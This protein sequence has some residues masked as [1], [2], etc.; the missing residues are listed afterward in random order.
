MCNINKIDL[1]LNPFLSTSLVL[2]RLSHL[3]F[4]LFFFLSFL[5]IVYLSLL[6]SFSGSPLP[7]P[8]IV[9]VGVVQYDNFSEGEVFTYNLLNGLKGYRKTWRELLQ[10]KKCH[11][12]KYLLFPWTPFVCQKLGLRKSKSEGKHLF[13]CRRIDL[14]K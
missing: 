3:K 13:T 11:S 2:P 8:H 12:R 5:L 10:W 7:H 4:S 6:L 1:L 9:E 14:G